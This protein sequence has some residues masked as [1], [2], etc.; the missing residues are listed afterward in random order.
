MGAKF[1]AKFKPWQAVRIADK[2]GKAAKVAG[3]AIQVGV[4]VA[5]VFT[6]EI[7]EARAQAARDRRRSAFISELMAMVD[8]IVSE[9]RTDLKNIVDPPFN[10]LLAH[11]DQLR[12]EIIDADDAR[13]TAG[14]NSPP[15]LL[16]LIGSS[17]SQPVRG[18]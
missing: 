14:P 9:A 17:A 8:E 3:F 11:L 7:N 13:G 2:I 18:S 10:D 15:S 4:T 6:T 12:D 5:S 1:G 16:T